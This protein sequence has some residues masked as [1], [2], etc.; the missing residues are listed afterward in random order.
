MCHSDE[1]V[2]RHHPGMVWVLTYTGPL[3]SDSYRST[4]V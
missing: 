2:T 4:A 3:H 1:R